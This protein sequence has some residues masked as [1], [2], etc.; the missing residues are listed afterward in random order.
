MFIV[1]YTFYNGRYVKNKQ[2]LYIYHVPTIYKE[3]L[4]KSMMLKNVII[5]R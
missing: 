4:I 2:I 5:K 3:L 1:L